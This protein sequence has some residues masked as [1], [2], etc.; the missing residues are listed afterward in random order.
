MPSGGM[1]DDDESSP[2][3]CQLTRCRAHLL[4]NVIDGTAWTEVIAWNGEADPVGVQSSREVAERRTVQRLP[5]AAMN[6]NHDRAFMITWKEIN[7][8]SRTRAVGNAARGVPLAIGRGVLCPTGEQ[9][10][11][12]RIPR[13]V[14]VFDLV[15]DSRVQDATT[16]VAWRISARRLLSSPTNASSRGHSSR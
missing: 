12:F 3:P 9:R 5:I 6:E 4:D 2:K 16:L 15:V 11:V 8:V 10:G 7:D 13:P 14:V 1:S